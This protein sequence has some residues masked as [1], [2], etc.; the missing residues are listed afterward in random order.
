M[1]DPRIPAPVKPIIKDYV[2]LTETRIIGLINGSYIV[3][4]I[5]LGEFNECFSDVDFITILNRRTT[6]IEMEHLRKIITP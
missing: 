6:P 2:R 4:S 5:A 3:G 1:M